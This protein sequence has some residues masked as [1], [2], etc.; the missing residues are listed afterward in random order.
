MMRTFFAIASANGW[1]DVPFANLQCTAAET[2][3]AIQPVNDVVHQNMVPT[4]SIGY[5][6]SSL[7]GGAAAAWPLAAHP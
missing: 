7:L 5:G 1:P 6:K 4:M 3:F 2:I